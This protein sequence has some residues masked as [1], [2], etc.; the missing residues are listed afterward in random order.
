[1]SDSSIFNHLDGIAIIGMSSRFPGAKNLEEFWQNLRNGLECI[2]FFSDQELQAS[3]IDPDVLNNS[4]YIKARAILENIEL[5]DALFFG[6]SPKEAAILDP[7]QR[8]FLE[9]AW[10]ALEIAGYNSETYNGL[11]GVYAGAHISTYLLN[12]LYTNPDLTELIGDLQVIMHGNDKDY[13]TT[14]VSYK[15]NLKGPSITVQTAC[16]TSL[17]AVCM[18]CQSLLSYQCDM[19]L[20]GGVS[21]VVPHRA[22]YMYQV[23]GILSPD[24]HCRAF[25]AKAQGTV[26]GNGV[27]I[28]VLKRLTDA[29]ADGDSI[30]AV[31]KGSAINNDGFL[32]V[33]Y[34]APSVDGQAEVIAEALTM[35]EFAPETVTYIEAHGTGTALGDPIEIAA[36]TQAFRATTDAKGF[37]ALGSVK[38]NIGHLNTA[39]GVAGLIKTALALKHKM[40]PP[41]LHFDQPNPQIDFTNSPFYVNTTLSAWQVENHPRRAGVSSFGIGGTNAHVVLEEAPPHAA[42]GPCRPWQV[43]VLSAKTRSALETVTTNLA[44]YLKQHPDLNLADVAYTL[45]VGRRAFGHRRM[46]VCQE[47]E[48]ALIALETLNRTWVFT[49]TQEPKDRPVTFMFPGQGAQYLNMAIELYQGEPTFREQVDLCSAHLKSHLGLDLR[50]VLYSNQETGR[51]GYAAT[52]S[53]LDHPTSTLCDRIC[54]GQTVDDLGN[55]APGDD[56]S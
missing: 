40:I 32:K 12:N 22:G 27:G 18:A 35:A 48:A 14:H 20:A 55:S 46:L 37:C 3:G 2:T 43:L 28:V 13:L 21:I 52:Q 11:T 25:D 42:S 39:A 50:A 10:D 5:F 44:E 19:A 24:G 34:T 51:G 6:F 41:S 54:P 36:L 1:M 16:S 56:W 29:L 47:L 15:L 8:L 45:Q 30:Y 31:I 38:T 26:P 53:D 17:V 23:G 33:G 7:Q 49:D 9:C 4:G